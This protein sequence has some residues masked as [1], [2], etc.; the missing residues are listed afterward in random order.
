[1]ANLSAP[2]RKRLVEGQLL[3]FFRQRAME[4]ASYEETDP[5][6]IQSTPMGWNFMNNLQQLFI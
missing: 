6:Q 5:T 1:M 4:Y 2:D 3:K